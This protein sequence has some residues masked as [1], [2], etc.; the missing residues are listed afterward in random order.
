MV[1]Q[2]G[3]RTLS[4]NLAWVYSQVRGGFLSLVKSKLEFIGPFLWWPFS[5]SSTALYQ[6][7]I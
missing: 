7:L 1:G 4:L 5:S 3:V 6:I 2:I